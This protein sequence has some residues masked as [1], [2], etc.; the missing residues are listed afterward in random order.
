MM[1]HTRNI[2]SQRAHAT[3]RGLQFCF[4]GSSMLFPFTLRPSC[5]PTPALCLAAMLSVFPPRQ[6]KIPPGPRTSGQ[7][8]WCRPL[9]G[10]VFVSK[11]AR[12]HT[13]RHVPER[14]LGERICVWEPAEIEANVHAVN[15]SIG[16]CSAEP[17]WTLGPSHRRKELQLQRTDATGP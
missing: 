15:L 13:E 9:G 16:K 7:A 10:K 3:T 1:Q 2:C 5:S 8:P 17:T 12:R 14:C 11:S 6:H 4:H